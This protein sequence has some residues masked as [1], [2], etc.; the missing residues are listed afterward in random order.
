VGARKS[1]GCSPPLPVGRFPPSL[2]ELRRDREVWSTTKQQGIFHQHL[3]R[4]LLE[5]GQ[6]DK[7]GRATAS[8]GRGVQ[9]VLSAKDGL[10]KGSSSK[11]IFR[12]LVLTRM[13]FLGGFP[14]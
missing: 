7:H 8:G 6:T 2:F 14:Y 1:F 3:A 9:R 13:V 5:R 4:L 12:D 10:K 11:E